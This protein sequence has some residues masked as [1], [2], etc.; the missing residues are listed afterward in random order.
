[1]KVDLDSLTVQ[2]HEE[3]E[4]CRLQTIRLLEFSTTRRLV[5]ALLASQD[6]VVGYHV[7]PVDMAACQEQQL[8]YAQGSERRRPKQ[9]AWQLVQCALLQIF[10]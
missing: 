8:L 6:R 9:G 7:V 2:A 10:R 5:K 1:M 4:E 3:E